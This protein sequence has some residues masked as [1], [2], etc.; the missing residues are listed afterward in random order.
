MCFLVQIMG[1]GARSTSWAPKLVDLT[2][3]SKSAA[4]FH[5]TETVVGGDNRGQTVSSH[6]INHPALFS[7]R[8]VIIPSHNKGTAQPRERSPTRPRRVARI[9]FLFEET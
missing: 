2:L 9:I 1:Y 3:T 6:E 8:Q 7:Q 5:L 4:A